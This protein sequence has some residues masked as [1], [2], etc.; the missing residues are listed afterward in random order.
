MEHV[1][2]IGDSPMT[3]VQFKKNLFYAV[4]P[5]HASYFKEQYPNIPNI[6][7]IASKTK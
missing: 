6:S 2:L 3:E 7:F 1:V 4:V 5:T